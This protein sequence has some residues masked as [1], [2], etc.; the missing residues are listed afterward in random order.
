MAIITTVL[1]QNVYTGKVSELV[2]FIPEHLETFKGS[3]GFGGV[4]VDNTVQS[5]KDWAANNNAVNDGDKIIILDTQTPEWAG[6]KTVLT[7]E[8]KEEN[9]WELSWHLC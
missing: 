4:T 8:F 2:K 9:D 7:P 5:A 6:N 3:A 1:N